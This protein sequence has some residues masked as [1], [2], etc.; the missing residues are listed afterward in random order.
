MSRVIVLQA[1]LG[2]DADRRF[3]PALMERLP[4][5]RRLELEER[6]AQS[7]SASLA[8]LRLVLDGLAELLGRPV[9]ADTLRF[10]QGGKPHCDGAGHFSISHTPCRVAVALSRDCEVGIDLEDFAPTAAHAP[11]E[12]ERLVRWTAT[13]AALKAAGLGL[14]DAREVA[15]ELDAGCARLEGRK[16][17]LRTLAL[18][19]DVV[20]HLAT[21]TRVDSLQVR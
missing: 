19:Q 6:D 11:A 2:E 15:L 16:F 14:R 18:G 17:F 4:Y 8:G 13:E 21:A 9:A 20:A 10:P 12:R 7:R 5:A 3:E 1:A